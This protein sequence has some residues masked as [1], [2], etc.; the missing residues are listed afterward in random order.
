M[1]VRLFLDRRQFCDFLFASLDD[2]SPSNWDLLLKERICSTGAN[3]K[4]L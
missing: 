3:S 4:I 2:K 1:S